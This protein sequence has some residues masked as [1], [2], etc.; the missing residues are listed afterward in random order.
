MA[1]EFIAIDIQGLE[2]VM[3][4]LKKLP[5]EAMDE[6]VEA[7]NEYLVNVMQQ[8]PPKPTAP[9]QWSSDKQRRYVMMKMRSEG[10]PGRNQTLRNAWKTVGSGY[11]QMIVNETPYAQYVQGDQQIVGHTANGWSTIDNIIKKNKEWL[12]KFEAGVKKA[13]HKLGLA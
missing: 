2:T 12:K 11:Q 4:R 1:N 6:G 13:I 5:K 3:M 10:Y 9:F 8:Y 7:A